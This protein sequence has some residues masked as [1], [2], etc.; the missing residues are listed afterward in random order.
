MSTPILTCTNLTKSYTAGKPVLHNLN[1]SL[2]G[3]KIVGLL[4]PNGCGKS[5]LLKLLLRFIPKMGGEVFCRGHNVDE[6]DRRRLAHF[7][8]YIPQSDQAIF[9]YTALEM[10]SMARSSYM[11]AFQSPKKEDVELAYRCLE[12][13]HIAHLADFPYNNMSGGQRQLVLIARALCQNTCILV[14]DEPTASLDFANQQLIND[15][16]RILSKEGKIVIVSTHS[17]AQPFA[18]GSHV[19]LM[20]QGS[21]LGFG[22]PEEILNDHSL[23]EVYGIPMEV[24]SV[25]DRNQQERKLCLSL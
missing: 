15:A 2:S 9:P 21:S 8:S 18:I 6:L 17:P 20:R 19:L 7:F 25:R 13:L 5:T 12:K 10:V 3:G 14:M 23:E 1:I 11:G 24:L 4:G 16:I 22:P